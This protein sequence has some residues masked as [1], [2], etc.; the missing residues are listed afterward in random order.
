VRGAGAATATSTLEGAVLL[1]DDDDRRLELARSWVRE[2]TPHLPVED[3]A[4]ALL[5][6]RRTGRSPMVWDVEQV[7]LH[8]LE[9]WEESVS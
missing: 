2:R 1:R 9:T 3:A 5:A 8:G 6:I 7:M 4:Q